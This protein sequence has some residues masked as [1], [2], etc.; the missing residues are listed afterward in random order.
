MRYTPEQHLKAARLIKHQAFEEKD[1]ERKAILE[2]M[3]EL[4]RFVAKVGRKAQDEA[5]AKARAKD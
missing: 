2:R 1:P 5:R 4:G 3:A